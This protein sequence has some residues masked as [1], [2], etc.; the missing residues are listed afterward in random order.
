MHLCCFYK[1]QD[2]LLNN[3]LCLLCLHDKITH[4]HTEYMTNGSWESKYSVSYTINHEKYSS[5]I[6]LH[7]DIESHAA[8]DNSHKMSFDTSLRIN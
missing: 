6:L 1:H 2:P 7:T 8:K 4:T 5:S 3:D